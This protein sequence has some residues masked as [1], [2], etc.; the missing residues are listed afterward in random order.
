MLEPVMSFSSKRYEWQFACGLI[1]GIK[2]TLFQ[3][4]KAWM[5]AIPNIRPLH[6]TGG[7]LP[8]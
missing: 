5:P 1:F 2:V 3:N 7:N 8:A 6:S 4:P